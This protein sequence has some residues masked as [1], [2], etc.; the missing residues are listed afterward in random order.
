VVNTLVVF[1]I[2]YLFNVRY[3][4][5]GSLTWQGVLGTPAVL[6]A[7]VVVV[8]AQL[9]FTYAPTMQRWFASA[10]VPFVDGLV[11]IAAGVALM[12]VLEAEKALLRRCRLFDEARG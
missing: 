8:V 5:G 7:L 10:P 3:L 4:H 2:F 12:L 6:I 1:E 11:I 9:A